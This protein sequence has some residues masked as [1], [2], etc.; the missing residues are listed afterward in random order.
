MGGKG[1]I[2]RRAGGGIC[3]ADR[4]V[5]AK[6][7]S[8]RRWSI[9]GRFSHGSI[10]AVPSISRDID[11]TLCTPFMHWRGAV[12]PALPRR[13]DLVALSVRSPQASE[14]DSHPARSGAWSVRRNSQG[15]SRVPG[16]RGGAQYRVFGKC[17]ARE[18]A[19]CDVSGWLAAH[20]DVH[21]GGGKVKDAPR[22]L[23]WF[24]FV[25]LGAR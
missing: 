4:C 13:P 25:L 8:V 24:T 9:P 14:P 19:R 5:R 22:L 17:G 15:H 21:D 6:N 18:G 1:G 11:T 3:R 16:W 7:G 20:E 23:F 10:V 2:K 12:H